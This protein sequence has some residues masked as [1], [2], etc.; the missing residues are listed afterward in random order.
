MILLLSRMDDIHV[1]VVAEMLDRRRAH[2][3]WL[4]P[5]SFHGATEVSASLSPR[6][7]IRRTWR[8]GPHQIDLESVKTAW[9]RR[10][11]SEQADPGLADAECSAYT[12]VEKRWFLV[13]LF[14]S[15]PCRWI[16]GPQPVF[17][18]AEMKLSQL[19]AATALGFELPPTLI[20]N[21]PGDFFAFYR[22]HEGK[23]IS[24]L[25]SS[26]FLNGS[27]GQRFA[28]Y[29]ERVRHRDLAHAE[30]IRSSP[31]IFQAYVDKRVELRATVVGERVFTAAI[32]SQATRQTRYDW[33]RYDPD[34]TPHTPF[35]LPPEIADRCC[36]LVRR[37]GLSYGAVDLILTPDGRY[38]FLEVNPNGQYL[39][40]ERA[41]GLPISDAICDLLISGAAA[42]VTNDE[43]LHP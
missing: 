29:T 33:R 4:D 10:P 12:V 31:M 8:C 20:T 27:F 32:H 1:R 6:D 26:A 41:T 16:P 15:L 13:D 9:Y 18:R 7:G 11:T 36:A 35:E 40:L 43:R 19:A 39:W 30:A 21:S 28:R 3:Q 38:V 5:G 17:R 23:I 42:A 25:P 34:H 37:L 22:E 24:K 2:Y 14:D